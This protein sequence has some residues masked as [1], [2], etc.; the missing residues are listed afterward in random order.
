[1]L[2]CFQSALRKQMGQT[3]KQYLEKHYTAQHSY[4]IIMNHFAGGKLCSTTKPC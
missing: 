4:N 3:A 2:K 1:V